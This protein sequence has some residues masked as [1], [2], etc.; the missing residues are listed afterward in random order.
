MRILNFGVRN[1]ATGLSIYPMPGGLPQVAG[2]RSASLAKVCREVVHPSP[3]GQVRHPNRHSVARFYTSA[4][5]EKMVPK[6]TKNVQDSCRE[7]V[8]LGLGAHP[9]IPNRHSVVRFYTSA[10]V[11]KIAPKTT[12]IGQKWAR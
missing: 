1:S 2:T 11:E 10:I 9:V 8:I 12:K 7:V 6:T 4:I 5:V 3:G